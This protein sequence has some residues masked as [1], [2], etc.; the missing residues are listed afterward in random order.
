M[1]RPAPRNVALEYLDLNATLRQAPAQS[2]ADHPGAD[3][4]GFHDGKKR[5]KES[6]SFLKKRS[7]KLL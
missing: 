4:G 6:T 1:T 2:E 3:D 5:G 7:K